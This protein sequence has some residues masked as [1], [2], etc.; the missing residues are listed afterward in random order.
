MSKR[1][2]INCDRCGKTITNKFDCYN[3]NYAVK[4]SS[5]KIQLWGVDVPRGSGGQR[6]DLCETCYEKFINFL[7]SEDQE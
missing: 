5:A 2:E 6:I 1:T 4:N 3:P 7:E